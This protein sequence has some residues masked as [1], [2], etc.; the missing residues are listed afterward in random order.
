LG[1]IHMR[2]HAKINLFLRV[3]GTRADGYHEIETIFQA[4]SLW[5]DVSVNTEA[6]GLTLQAE[7]APGAGGELPPT[8]DNLMLRAAGI[9]REAAGGSRGASMRLVKRIPIGGGLGGGS[10][11]AAAVLVGLNE[12]WD[13]PLDAD[14]MRAGAARLGSDVSFFLAGGTALATSRGEELSALVAPKALWFVLG[15]SDE[16]LRTSDVYA[17]SDGLETSETTSGPMVVALGAGDVAAI[18][19]LLHNDLEVAAC[20]VRPDLGARKQALLEAGAVGACT[21]GSGPTLYALATSEDHARAIARAVSE[22]FDRVAVVSSRT[23][24]VEL[25]KGGGPGAPR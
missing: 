18:G 15:I 2:A 20:S 25:L 1:S 22:A 4:V 12:L 8:A 13:R 19:A 16:P 23:S 24:A 14:A 9:V 5:D 11:D 6:R 3:L 7:L 17:R 10:A 21:S